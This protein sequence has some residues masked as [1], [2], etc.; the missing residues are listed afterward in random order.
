MRILAWPAYKNRE[1]PYNC[2]LYRHV[3]ELGVQVAE[4][5]TLRVITGSYS[6]WHIHWPERFWNDRNLL[7]ALTKAQ[8][9]L[10]LLHIARRRGIRIVWTV[11]NLGAHEKL[12]PRIE[13]RF[14]SAFI[15]HVDGYF[16]LT[17]SGLQ[18]TVER[19]PELKNRPGFVAPLGTYR[20]VYPDYVNKADARAA[21]DISAQARVMLFFGL[22]RPYKGV[23]GLI[24]AFRQMSD[25]NAVLV[26]AGRASGDQLADAI[27]RE[28]EGDGRIRLHLGFVPDERVQLFFR[29]AD[30][31]ALPFVEVLNSSSAMLSLAFDRPVLVPRLGALGELQA[32]VGDQWVRFFTG[33]LDP[34]SLENALTWC[35]STERSHVAPLERF[36][37]NNVARRTVAAYERVVSMAVG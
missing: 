22:I 10:W 32:V 11:H 28:A 6:V 35:L 9:C 25:P 15:R 24:G 12:Y 36:D 37:W 16:C 3:R 23:Q 7:R 26:I 34:Q 27:R 19:V 20:G 18:T 21:L 1:N 33:S 5:S 17:E 8:I 29:A 30:L 14:W 4:F 31:V 13:A 2:L